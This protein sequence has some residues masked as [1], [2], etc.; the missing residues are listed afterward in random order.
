MGDAVGLFS[1]SLSPIARDCRALGFTCFA[2]LIVLAASPH[3]FAS[4]V[5]DTAA[6]QAPATTS[7]GAPQPRVAPADASTQAV[8]TTA[9]S[10]VVKSLD[11]TRL[12]PNAF[13]DWEQPVR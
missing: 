5:P 8:G 3:A 6:G 9:V 4:G 10:I 1:Q 12:Q 2:G 7:H 13:A 11:L